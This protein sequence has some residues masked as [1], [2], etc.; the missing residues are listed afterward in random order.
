MR[1]VI[2]LGKEV[3]HETQILHGQYDT[4]ADRLTAAL[5]RHEKTEREQ[6]S[7]L[8]EHKKSL[9]RDI[10]WIEEQKQIIDSFITRMAATLDQ[11][12][13]E[14]LSTQQMHRPAR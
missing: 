7:A 9:T 10:E 6:L 4:D 14:G 1:K 11:Y 8:I 12:L 13:C 5:M 3:R 2:D